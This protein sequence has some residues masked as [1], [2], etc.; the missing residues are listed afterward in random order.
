M[1]LTIE[2]YWISLTNFKKDLSLKEEETK[3]MTIFSSYHKMTHLH[4]ALRKKKP[5]IYRDL[6]KSNCDPFST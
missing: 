3:L 5:S 4:Y 6:M 1:R 2:L